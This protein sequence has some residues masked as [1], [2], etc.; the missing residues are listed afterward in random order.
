VTRFL[1]VAAPALIALAAS[2]ASGAERKKPPPPEV[3]LPPID[4]LPLPTIPPEPNAPAQKPPEATAPARPVGIGVGVAGDLDSAAAARL[5]ASLRSIAAL[6]PLAR[7]P[8]ALAAERCD[9]DACVSALA[10]AQELDRAVFARVARGILTV[11]VVDVTFARPPAEAGQPVPADGAELRAAGEALACGLLVPAGCTG[12]AQIDAAGAAIEIDAKPAQTRA[13][14][15]VG[16][17][18]IVVRSGDSI[19]RRPL[20]VVVEKPVAMAVRREQG[21]IVLLTP[22]EMAQ[23]AVVS[24]EV[25]APARSGWTRTAGYVAA[26]AGIVAAGVAIAEGLHSR[27]LINDAENGYRANGNVYRPRDLGNLESGN[28]AAHTANL[29]FAASGVLLA[30]GLVLAFAF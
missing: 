9:T 6:V 25:P 20:P 26:G 2:A 16:V 5:A 15:P 28:S 12:V 23:R 13:T 24:A 21:K 22:E 29:L 30:S 11:R 14:L 27:S 1:A 7:E 10:A 17:H 3:P 4:Q 19:V 18:T 8:V